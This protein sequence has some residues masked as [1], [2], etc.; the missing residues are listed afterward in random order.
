MWLVCS[1]GVV[2]LVEGPNFGVP[3]RSPRSLSCTPCSRCGSVAR[4]SMRAVSE[5]ESPARINCDSGDILGAIS[6]GRGS[7]AGSDITART[8][9]YDHPWCITENSLLRQ[10]ENMRRKRY[11]LGCSDATR[12]PFRRRSRTDPIPL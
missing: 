6:K 10:N 12:A 2:S 7:K 8:S 11:L 1:L 9:I 5:S 3:V 4:S